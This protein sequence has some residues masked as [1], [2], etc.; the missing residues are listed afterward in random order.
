MKLSLKSL[1]FKSLLPPADL[2]WNRVRAVCALSSCSHKLLMRTVPGNRAG[3]H[4]GEAWFCSTDCFAA[5]SCDTLWALSSGC[6][7]EM[8]PTPRL[9]LGL[10]LLG[11]GHITEDQLR[12]ATAGNQGRGT[13]FETTLIENGFI[14]EKQLA[15]GRAIQWGYPAL[16]QEL[17]AQTVEADLPPTLL[18][19]CSAAPVHYSPK[20]RRLVLGFV[21]RVEHGLLQSIEQI[22]GY[23]AEP[24]FI[25]QTEFEEQMERL[26]P[27]EGYKEVPFEDSGTVVQMARTLGGI[28]QEMAATEAGFSRCKSWVWTRIL[29]KR[30]ITDVVFSM[31]NVAAPSRSRL[32]A[33]VPEVTGALG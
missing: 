30:G 26:K 7:V 1:S 10:V 9:S 33:L 20:S 3:I 5:A 13:S 12:F 18:R 16:G 11:K 19:A 24:C 15:A 28:A 14:T 22:T 6:V 23:R 17:A 25:T 2:G 27:A 4:V 32:T 8:P 31:K 29:G 21:H